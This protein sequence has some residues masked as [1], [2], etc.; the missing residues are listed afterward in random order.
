MLLNSRGILQA[1]HEDKSFPGENSN[2]FAALVILFFLLLVCNK[3][4]I[5]Y[6]PEQYRRRAKR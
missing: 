2:L 1:S 5:G 6:S 4:E 3:I